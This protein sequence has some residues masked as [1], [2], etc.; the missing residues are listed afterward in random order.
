MTYYVLCPGKME[1]GG[2]ELAHQLCYSLLYMGQEAYMY[3]T[4]SGQMEPLDVDASPKFYKYGTGHVKSLADINQNAIFIVPEALTTWGP[5][6]PDGRKV[7]WWM[8]VDNYIVTTGERNLKWI[9]QNVDY[10]FVQSYYAKNYL[11]ERTGISEEKIL[12]LSDYIGEKYGKF[13]FPVQY[14]QNIALYN[15]AKGYEEIRPLIEATPWLKWLPLQGLNEEEMIVRMQAAKV[16]VDFGNHPGK[17]R[18]PKEAAS[19]GCCVITNK[20]GSAAFYEDVPIPDEY[21][22]DDVHN[23]Y[24]R[25]AALLQDICGNYEVHVQEFEVYRQFIAGEKAQFENDVQNMLCIFQQEFEEKG[26][27]ADMSVNEPYTETYIQE[28]E[29][30]QRLWHE[31]NMVMEKNY[32]ARIDN[33]LEQSTLEARQTLVLLFSD[34]SFLNIFGARTPIAYMGV[35]MKIYEKEIMAGEEHTI[36]D[37]GVSYQ[38]IIGKLTELKF[39]LWRIIFANQKE[40]EGMLLE[41]IRQNNATPY[42]LQHL[43]L[44][45]SVNKK[46]ILLKLADLFLKQNMLRFAFHM[47]DYMTQLFPEDESS[48]CMTADFCGSTGNIKQAGAYLSKIK[49]PGEMTERIRQKYGC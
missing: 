16:Y 43:V 5:L 6:L 46:E 13:I 34:S 27:I 20:K 48:W 39:I 9:E 2:P 23:S 32:L 3:Y 49:N 7:I 41:F 25:I 24:D 10:H 1:S 45:A 40:G 38:G 17:D 26:K 35:V 8:S 44:T 15:P 36:L 29:R 4:C 28:E 37:M 18:I 14:R 33:L 31:K 47:L 22:F 12:Y 21:K 19:C 11:R 42:M 30:Q